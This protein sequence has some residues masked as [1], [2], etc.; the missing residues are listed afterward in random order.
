MAYAQSYSA[1]EA[2]T[3]PATFAEHGP[4]LRRKGFP[5]VAVNPD[6]KV[7]MLRGFNKMRSAPS[8]ATVERWALKHPTAGIGLLPRFMN[9]VICDVDDRAALPDALQL[10]GPTNHVVATKRGA[11]LYYRGQHGTRH[12]QRNLGLP[13][14]VIGSTG[15]V[16]V[17]P[18][19]HKSGFQYR[20]E[21][22]GWD[23]PADP[24]LFNPSRMND[25]LAAR[26]LAAAKPSHMQAT[27]ETAAPDAAEG[28][29]ANLDHGGRWNGINDV[30]CSIAGRHTD[31]QAFGAAAARIN[32]EMCNPPLDDAELGRAIEHV[33]TFRLSNRWQPFNGRAKVWTDNDEMQ[34]LNAAGS[35]GPEALALLLHL[36]MQH[37][38][39]PDRPFHLT[40]R[41]MAD[42]NVLNGWGERKY[43]AARDL[44]LAVGKLVL[45][46][47][48]RPAGT[49]I[50]GTR[51]QTV[52]RQGA[53][54][55]LAA[56]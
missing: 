11:H 43:R 8:I 19:V 14:D 15:Y 25:A 12:L 13:I 39:N 16:A 10:F 36:R 2:S 52:G 50:R 4:A 26:K 41:A 7:P 21:I 51:I 9:L 17:P 56:Y 33:W 42:A 55:L 46:N 54:Y 38:A 31:Q 29:T 28:R 5:I 35:A 6:T 1:G 53:T 27:G 20:W 34:A 23:D 18:S 48:Y 49:V 30:L 24:P 40:V 3:R 47:S 44:L 45:V 22:G 37:L 32:A